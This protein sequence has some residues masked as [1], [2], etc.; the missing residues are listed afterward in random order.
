MPTIA[1]VALPGSGGSVTGAGTYATS[2]VVTLTAIPNEGYSFLNWSSGSKSNPLTFKASKDETYTAYFEA[3]K[4]TLS[5]ACSPTDGGVVTGAGT[6]SYGTRIMLGA[7]P[8]AGYAFSKWSDGVPSPSR[9]VTVTND[10]TYTAEFVS[11]SADTQKI[12]LGTQEAV[13][14]VK[15]VY[16]GKV[17]F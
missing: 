14:N 4:Y 8:N 16:I 7:T 6:F 5:T 13:S 1:T 15:A 12:C 9:S 17:K 3:K 2:Q 11:T 10:A